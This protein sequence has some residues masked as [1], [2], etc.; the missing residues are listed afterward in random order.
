MKSASS[1]AALTPAHAPLVRG[2]VLF[3]TMVFAVLWLLLAGPGWESWLIGVPAIL[4]AAGVS[5]RLAPRWPRLAPL[6]VLRFIPFFLWQSV[7]G[8]LDVAMRVLHPRLQIA[9]AFVTYQLRL[10]DPAAQ[11]V[12]LDVISLLPGTLSA[13]LRGMVVI[14]H[15]LDVRADPLAEL[16]QLESQI[17][18]LF[19]Q[20]LTDRCCHPALESPRPFYD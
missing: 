20:K 12:L 18:A 8:G 7:R 15:V 6:G 1:D 14:V 5:A 2:T 17:A 9:P 13:E 4:A 19:A 16:A 11:V 10:T 3:R